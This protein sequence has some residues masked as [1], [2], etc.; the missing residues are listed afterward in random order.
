MSVTVDASSIKHAPRSP[1]RNLWAAVLARAIEDI[2]NMPVSCAYYKEA[3]KVREEAIALLTAESGEWARQRAMI[4]AYIDRDPDL[5]RNQIMRRMA[6]T[7]PPEIPYRTSSKKKPTMTLEQKRERRRFFAL[8]I[9][10]ERAAADAAH[11]F[12]A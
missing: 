3:V 7:P 12:A 1:E 2:F 8:M 11:D 10:L 9:F 4:C 6:L 5:V